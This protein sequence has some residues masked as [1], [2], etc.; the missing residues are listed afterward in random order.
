MR[1][2]RDRCLALLTA[3]ALVLQPAFAVATAMPAALRAASF[4]ICRGDDAGGPARSAQDQCDACLA[5]HCA[6][7]SDLP[8]RVA[9]AAPWR[10]TVRVA[11]AAPRGALV[12]R[13]P[14]RRQH[15][16]RAPPA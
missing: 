12:P 10:D 6:G 3:Y 1:R 14:A 5:G 7:T 8:E 2:I 4:A 15:G 13:A 16:Q 11:E 9:L